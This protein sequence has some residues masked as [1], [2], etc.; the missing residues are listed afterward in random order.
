MQR[1]EWWGG[2]KA[3]GAEEKAGVHSPPSQ[4]G[5]SAGATHALQVIQRSV[6]LAD[7]RCRKPL[8]G[9]SRDK[10]CCSQPAS[11]APPPISRG[12]AEAE[13]E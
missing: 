8:S 10:P 12:Q 3:E 11:D 9:C 6:G 1:A 5:A 13:A 2:Q 4:L 7:Y